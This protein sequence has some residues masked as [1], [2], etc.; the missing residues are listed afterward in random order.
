MSMLRHRIPKLVIPLACIVD[1]YGFVFEVQTPAPLTLSTLAYGSD[2]EGLLLKDDD[3]TA[4]SIA[5]QVAKLLNIMPRD[6]IER[7]TLIKK[8]ALLP[9]DVQ[10]HRSPY[11][12][13]FFLVNAHR[14]ISQEEPVMNNAIDK[15]LG[16]G[17]IDHI[18]LLESMGRFLRP[19]YTAS[20]HK[21]EL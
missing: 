12:D 7:S 15:N 18:T 14:L 4:R 17:V 16:E 20:N 3:P 10:I 21:N 9:I 19:E 1:Y 13:E 6:F 5:T 8:D 11:R 2:T